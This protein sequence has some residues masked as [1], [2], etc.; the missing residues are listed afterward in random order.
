MIS[1]DDLEELRHISF[2]IVSNISGYW[3]LRFSPIIA[4]QEEEFI[5]E[6]K[7]LGNEIVL[8]AEN[9]EAKQVKP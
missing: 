1:G 2:L 4:L 3:K 5:N 9:Q 8:W 7:K 6:I